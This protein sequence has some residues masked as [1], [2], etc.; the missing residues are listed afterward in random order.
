MKRMAIILAVSLA[1]TVASRWCIGVSRRQEEYRLQAIRLEFR[2][3]NAELMIKGMGN[4]GEPIH[5]DRDRLATLDRQR[6]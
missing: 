1:V 6:P 4:G 3:R 2:V 5:S